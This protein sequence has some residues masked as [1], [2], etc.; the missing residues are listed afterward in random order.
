MSMTDPIADLLTRIRNANM[1]RLSH[2]SVPST[3]IKQNIVG[4]LQDEGFIEAWEM[5]DQKDSFPEIQ[6]KLKYMKNGNPVMRKIYRESKPGL[7]LYLK[8]NSI[9]PVLG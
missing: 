9:K 4:L 5:K 1:R 3:K 7:R 2:V 8:A 6:I